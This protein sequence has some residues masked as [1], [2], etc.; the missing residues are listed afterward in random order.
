MYAV[1]RVRGRTGIKRDIADTL[2]MLRLTRVNHCV[3]IPDTPAYRG[4]LQKVKDYVTWGEIDHETLVELI[5][6]R[7]RLMGDKPITDEYV[8]EHTAFD[9]IEEFAKAVVEGRVEYRDLPGV[10]PVFRLHPPIGGWEKIKRSYREG[11]ALGYRGSDIT[12]LIRRM[13]GPGRW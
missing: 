9:G 6:A 2:K 1:I 10:K 3:L 4:M 11:G 12:A 7:G 8:R 5:R 13:L